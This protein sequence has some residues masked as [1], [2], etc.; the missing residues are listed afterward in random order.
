V[1]TNVSNAIQRFL[2]LTLS[3]QRH[4]YQLLRLM[5]V[6]HHNKRVKFVLRLHL[7]Q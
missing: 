3:L 6:G 5:F 2:Q 7:H 4:Y 1:A